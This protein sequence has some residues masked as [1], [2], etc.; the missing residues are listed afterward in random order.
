MKFDLL[1]DDLSSDARGLSEVEPIGIAG[2][3]CPEAKHDPFVR[4]AGLSRSHSLQVGTGVAVAFA[5]TPMLVAML[6]NDLQ[7]ASEGRFLLGLGSQA[8]AHVQRRFSMEWGKP[9]AR[10]REFIAALHA[11]WDAWES[12]SPLNHQGEY[13]RH[14]L[15]PPA[16]SPGP[17]PYGR[18]PVYLAALGP[19][20][21]E[22]A[23][24]DADGLVV[25]RFTGQHYIEREL[26]P[27]LIAALERRQRPLTRPF[28][29]VYTP[30]LVRPDDEDG[31]RATREQFAF[32]ASADGFRPVLAMNG[33]E[34]LADQL[35]AAARA[36]AWSSMG[37][38][39]DDTTLEEFAFVGEGRSLRDQLESQLGEYISRM[40]LDRDSLLALGPPS[41]PQQL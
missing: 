8:Q 20:M 25:H 29:I 27:R 4:L 12:G 6:A 23:G 10:M 14:S 17:N 15:M 2:V 13:Y 38:L 41:S 37:S 30:H 3:W 34:Y 7:I 19:R 33:K 22:L 35:Q 36:R 39:I 5:R 9:I 1:L 31:F 11:I 24:M 16:F 18:P 32:F 40:P 26:Y 28:E 21:I